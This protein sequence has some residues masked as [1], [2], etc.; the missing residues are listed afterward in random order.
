MD[1]EGNKEIQELLS[2]YPRLSTALDD[3]H[4]TYEQSEETM[5]T[6]PPET[7]PSVEA[8]S[9]EDSDYDEI[10]ESA[11]RPVS[12]EGEWDQNKFVFQA[13]GWKDDRVVEFFQDMIRKYNSWVNHH[14]RD[15]G[16]L[17]VLESV[18]QDGFIVSVEQCKPSKQS[19]E[20]TL[21]SPCSDTDLLSLEVKI[22]ARGG[23][24]P[25]IG[26]VKALLG[27]AKVTIPEGM[28]E[29]SSPADIVKW[30]LKSSKQL[31]RFSVRYDLANVALIK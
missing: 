12:F 6:P 15:T 11:D 20:T 1:L 18:D 21:P 28:T 29:E 9:D 14:I 31:N 23:A 4:L 7:T 30:A 16:S 17:F 22:P 5:E 24:D 27:S 8:E 3:I 13:K 2:G 25:W 10:Q 19:Q 26:S